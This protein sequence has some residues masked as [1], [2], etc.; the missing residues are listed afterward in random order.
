LT[1]LPIGRILELCLQGR[2]QGQDLVVHFGLGWP[3]EYEFIDPDSTQY[4]TDGLS[5]RYYCAPQGKGE[6]VYVQSTG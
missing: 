6:A 3:S 4:F 5:K 2:A 1:E